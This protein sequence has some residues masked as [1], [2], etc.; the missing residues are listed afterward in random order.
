MSLGVSL[1][2]ILAHEFVRN[3]NLIRKVES[4]RGIASHCEVKASSEWDSKSFESS[5]AL[6]DHEV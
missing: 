6:R 2:L 1:L 5:K 3:T 4:Q